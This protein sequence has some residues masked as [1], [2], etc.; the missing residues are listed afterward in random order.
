MHEA[1]E[2]VG[3][4]A[5]EV[6]R[7]LGGRNGRAPPSAFPSSVRVAGRASYDWGIYA[8]KGSRADLRL[9]RGFVPFGTGQ[10]TVAVGVV[11]RL[12]AAA[13]IEFAKDVRNVGAG[14]FPADEQR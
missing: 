1:N 9:V 11:D 13:D 6:S 14:G 2:W 3:N 4:T 12:R 8:S 5:E 10:Q 7:H